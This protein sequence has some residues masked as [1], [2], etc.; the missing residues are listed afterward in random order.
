MKRSFDILFSVLVLSFFCLPM[1]LVALLVRWTSKGPALYWS[2]RVGRNNTIFSMPKFR[3]MVTDTPD[4]ATH[5]LEDPDVYLTPVG[6]FLRKTSLDELPQIYCI[7][8]GD[9]SVVGPRPALYNQSD[10]IRGRT[11]RGIHELLPGL[12]GWAQINGRD[13]LTIPQKIEFDEYYLRNQSF[14][15]DFTIVVRTL[16]SAF[17]RDGVSH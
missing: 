5:L 6:Q 7:I 8:K 1:G 4:V 14:S 3:T 9:M 15:F 11:N 2:D 13:E 12:T 10:L 16:V 17:R